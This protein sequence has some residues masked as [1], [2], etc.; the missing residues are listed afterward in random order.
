MGHASIKTVDAGQVRI[1][2]GHWLH[3][4]PKAFLALGAIFTVASVALGWDHRG[5]FHSA[6]LIA[7]TFFLSIALGGLFFC[8]IHHVARAGWSVVV[9]RIA[10]NAAGTLP[11]LALAFIPVLLGMHEL[12]EWT[13]ADV[14]AADPIL[15]WKSGYL[16]QTFF[17]I[18]AVFYF[19][20]W[21]FMVRRFRGKSV[22]QDETGGEE[23]T[24]NMQWHAGYS[25]LLF[26]FTV[27]FAVFDWLMSLDPHWFSTIFGAYYFAGSVIAIYAFLALN[28]LLLQWSGFLGDVVTTEHRWDIGKMLFA[29]TVF[30]TY[31]AFSQFILIW[32]ANLP[33]E[34]G[35][36][37]VRMTG[38]RVLGLLLIFGHFIVPFF[39]LMPRNMKKNPIALFVAAKWLMFIHFV[40]LCFLVLP[41]FHHDIG[42]MGGRDWLLLL[43]C[44][45]AVGGLFFGV[46]CRLMTQSALVPVKDPRLQESLAF[47]N[48]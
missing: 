23:A 41:A 40:D 31:M 29:F 30:W 12:F 48:A 16:N 22:A 2:E 1:P 37:D 10:E 25:L 43:T 36:F 35:W 17:V 28:V 15:Q 20:A 45:L 27:T 32:Y 42:S 3:S 11:W 47:E 9:R 19:A 46:Y 7:F 4:T 34:T 8:L 44:Y 33:E 18:R 5:S 38:W 13:H 24:R 14:V 39:F 26:A 6:W 21:A